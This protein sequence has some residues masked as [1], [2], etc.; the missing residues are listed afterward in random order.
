MCVY[1][2]DYYSVI[3]KNELIPFAR[4]W[5]DLETVILNEVR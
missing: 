1:T 4:M 3:K 2:M 5:I